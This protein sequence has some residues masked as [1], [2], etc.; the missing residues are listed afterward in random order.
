MKRMIALTLLAVMLLG[1]TACGTVNK[2]EVSVLW[3]DLAYDADG[4]IIMVP[5]SLINAVERAMYIENIAYNHY[6]GNADAATQLEQA[7]TAVDSGCSALMVQLA[8]PAAAQQFVDL[9][10]GKDIP[11]L[12]FGC[13]VDEI[14]TSGYEKCAVVRTDAAS[15]GTVQGNMIVKHL[16]DDKNADAL[17]TNG[18]GKLN[19]LALGDVA[20]AAEMS[21]AVLV[22]VE[23]EVQELTAQTLDKGK[24]Q[25]GVLT[26]PDGSAVELIIADSDQAVLE[27]MPYLQQLGFNKDKLTTHCVGIFT[28]GSDADYKASVLAGKPESAEAIKAYFE[29]NRYLV[30]LT[31]VKEEDLDE[32]VYNTMNVID[33]GRILNT[34]MEDHDALAEQAAALMASLLKG[35]AISEAYVAVPYKPYA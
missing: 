34:V 6:D 5:N 23:A 15:V 32:M 4:N 19:Y 18:D 9:A 26:A 31:A 30:D 22:K 12:F 28:V 7:Q 20:T 27:V 13:D 2:T 21:A 8:D 33:A 29:E 24:D 35:E 1:L 25:Y 10:Q 11:V 3:A 14:V 16:Q 17:D